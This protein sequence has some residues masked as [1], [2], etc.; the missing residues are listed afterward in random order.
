MKLLNQFMHDLQL[1]L[2][3]QLF[4]HT[5]VT[6]FTYGSEVWGYKNLDIIEQIHRDFL[7]KISHSRRIT[8]V[9]M[10][11]YGAFGSYPSQL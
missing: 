3:I 8:H 1:D 11:Y 5:I 4:D 9:Y 7:R 6:I 10:L 2:V